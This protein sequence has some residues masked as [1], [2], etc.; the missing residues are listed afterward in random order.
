MFG[1]GFCVNMKMTME[2][3]FVDIGSNSIKSLL[4]DFRGGKLVAVADRSEHSRISSPEGLKPDAAQIIA[5]AVNSLCRRSL[6]NSDKFD[7]F[8]FGTSALRESKPTTS[9]SCSHRLPMTANP[10]GINPKAH[11]SPKAGSTPTD[12]RALTFRQRS[13][14]SSPRNLDCPL[15]YRQTHCSAR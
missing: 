8:C 13:A 4:A 14:K 11:R 1:A 15:T 5:D 12:F 10:H 7:V 6:K 2:T 3:L 9:E